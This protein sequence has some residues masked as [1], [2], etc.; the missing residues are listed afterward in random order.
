MRFF[1]FPVAETWF[2]QAGQAFGRVKSVRSIGKTVLE[3]AMPL[4]FFQD[5]SGFGQQS[6]FYFGGGCRVG[7]F[8]D[9]IAERVR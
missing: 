8:G 9:Q 6:Y 3:M 5:R 2:P 7:G 4:S 1:Q